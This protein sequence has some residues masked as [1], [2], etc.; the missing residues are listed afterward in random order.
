MGRNDPWQGVAAAIGI[1][2]LIGAG[3]GAGSALMYA[4]RYA[5]ARDGELDAIERRLG[6]LEGLGERVT[7]LEARARGSNA[8]EPGAAAG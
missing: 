3:V 6:V 5:G 2:A 1:A 8:A 4:R 7:R